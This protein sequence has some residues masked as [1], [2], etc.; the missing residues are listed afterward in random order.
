M[1]LQPGYQGTIHLTVEAKVASVSNENGKNYKLILRGGFDESRIIIVDH[2]EI[3]QPI[4]RIDCD[5]ALANIAAVLRCRPLVSEILEAITKRDLPLQ[6]ERTAHQ[7]TSEELLVARRETRTAITLLEKLQKQNQELLDEMARAAPPQDVADA[8][9][10]DS[11]DDDDDQGE[12][13]EQEPWTPPTGN[14]GMDST[15]N[16]GMDSF[17][18]LL[19]AALESLH[20]T[21][22]TCSRDWAATKSDAWLYG[23]VAG[24]DECS[25]DDIR[26][27]HGWSTDVLERLAELHDAFATMVGCAGIPG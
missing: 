14:D 9:V 21:M 20:T 15:G 1:E 16:D 11:D 10:D 23:L 3:S 25:W 24:W 7:A 17:P 19:I 4:D 5:A 27:K 22:V 2:E 26:D 8:V 18:P 13:E 12:V 6:R